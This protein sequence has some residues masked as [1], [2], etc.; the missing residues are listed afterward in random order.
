MPNTLATL[1]SETGATATSD[2]VRRDLPRWIGETLARVS[3]R[4]MSASLDGMRALPAALPQ[5]R[6][7]RFV[8]PAFRVFDANFG[9]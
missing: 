8:Q 9:P 2:S 1:S 4:D 6:P 7:E 3:D 5:S